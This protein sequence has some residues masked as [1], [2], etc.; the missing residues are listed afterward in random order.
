MPNGL[1]E[2]KKLI[3]LIIIIIAHCYMLNP[4]KR[5]G[6]I[7]DVYQWGRKIASKCIIKHENEHVSFIYNEIYLFKL[8]KE[9]CEDEND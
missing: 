7:Y 9:I 3:F 6:Y 5:I 2:M 1:N 4:N 8:T